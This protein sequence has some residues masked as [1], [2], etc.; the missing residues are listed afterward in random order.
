MATKLKE[1]AA[2]SAASQGWKVLESGEVDPRELVI[3]QEANGRRYPADRIGEMV[4]S[5]LTEGQKA[6]ICVRKTEKDKLS[7]VFGY[8]RALAGQEI[9]ENNLRKGF[10]L[11]YELVDVDDLTAFLANMTE[12]DQREDLT[13]IDH[14]Y[15]FQRLK[16]QFGMTLQDINKR[17][18][19]SVSWISMTMK[20]LNLTAAQQ[21]QVALYK[22][23]N[24]KSGFSAAVGYELADMEP[25]ERQARIDE[26]KKASPGKKITRSAVRKAKSR[27]RGGE[28]EQKARTAKEIRFPF[29][30][31]YDEAKAKAKEE[32]RDLTAYENI[33]GDF[34]KFC[35]GKLGER[36]MLAHL[37]E[38]FDE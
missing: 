25:E 17:T 36:G 9:F 11:R 8:R 26:V 31:A 2:D 12:N 18:G 22:T 1:A 4:V 16:E 6:P 24:G 33:L 37:R 29:E 14:A 28:A 20:L 3:N 7:V 34:S 15:N 27:S 10:R 35:L 19:H 30:T 23:S 13:D 38:A 5:L 32:E 21:R